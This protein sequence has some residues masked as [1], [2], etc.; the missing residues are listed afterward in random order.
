MISLLF[1]FTKMLNFTII[2]TVKTRLSESEQ[3]EKS[4][5]VTILDSE[6]SD[7]LAL[8]IKLLFQKTPTI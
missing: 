7:W 4:K 1:A 3:K 2:P 6:P 5:S 8:P